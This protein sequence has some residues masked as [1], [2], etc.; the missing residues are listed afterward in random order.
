MTVPLFL[1]CSSSALQPSNASQRQGEKA[2][3]AKATA[4][5][6]GR[7]TAIARFLEEAARWTTAAIG[8]LNNPLTNG[9]FLDWERAE[10]PAARV[11]GTGKPL[12]RMEAQRMNHYD[13]L[14]GEIQ[15]KKGNIS[16]VQNFTTAH[17]AHR[18]GQYR[19]KDSAAVASSKL[20]GYRA[21]TDAMMSHNRRVSAGHS[22][23]CCGFL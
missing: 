19:A 14:D 8:I 18:L 13:A 11:R 15:A 2:E 4:T 7:S 20:E 9:L 1:Q 21:A 6:L 16:D 12:H 5:Q 23:W 22:R 17:A 3:R 10:Q